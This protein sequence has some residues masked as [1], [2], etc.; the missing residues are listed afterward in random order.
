[1][2][3]AVNGLV[4]AGHSI[5]V[6][7]DSDEFW[8]VDGDTLRSILASSTEAVVEGYWVNFV[9]RTSRLNSTD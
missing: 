4:A 6:P 7:F 9:Q 2:S 1:M 8:D 5:I 3:E